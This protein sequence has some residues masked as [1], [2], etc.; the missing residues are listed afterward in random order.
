MHAYIL[1]CPVSLVYVIDNSR[2]G[3][4]FLALFLHAYTAA[5]SLP[6]DNALSS[7]CTA[8]QAV[9]LEH[10]IQFHAWTLCWSIYAQKTMQ[11]AIPI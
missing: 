7:I 11:W 8:F 2:H 6:S 10:T 1:W 4:K 9:T 5:P 3:L